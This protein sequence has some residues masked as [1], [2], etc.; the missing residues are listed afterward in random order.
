M[1]H[2]INYTIYEMGPG[3]RFHKKMNANMFLHCIEIWLHENG[4][5]L[6]LLEATN[7]RHK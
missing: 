1:T 2:V 7:K 6:P 4:T 3:S 5:H